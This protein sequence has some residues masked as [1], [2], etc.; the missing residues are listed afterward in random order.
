MTR[1]LFVQR[2]LVLTIACSSAVL[3]NNTGCKSRTFNSKK[4]LT[5]AKTANSSASVL[6]PYGLALNFA[7]VATPQDASLTLNE[8]V[9]SENFKAI[10]ENGFFFIPSSGFKN[11][12]NR[13][14]LRGFRY[15]QNF[16][17]ALVDEVSGNL[18][19][20]TQETMP[21]ECAIACNAQARRI[22]RGQ[23]LCFFEG[24]KQSDLLTPKRLQGEIPPNLPIKMIP[25]PGHAFNVVIYGSREVNF[26]LQT[27]GGSQFQLYFD[28]KVLTKFTEQPELNVN[29]FT[30]AV[31]L[32]LIENTHNGL[33]DIQCTVD[34]AWSSDFII[35]TG[36]AVAD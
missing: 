22:N 25:V 8:I 32:F 23:P 28:C 7:T 31:S 1:E 5:G 13:R 2:I 20:S 34:D 26:Q 14:A 17:C 15:N 16:L 24:Q 11:G 9:S 10:I 12:P 21:I 3:L 27:T 35:I 36:T 4:T 19:Y 18:L 6:Q 29:P 30:G 33:I